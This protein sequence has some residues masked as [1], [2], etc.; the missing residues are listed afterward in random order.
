MR[1]CRERLANP[2]VESAFSEPILDERHLERLDHLLPLGV[3]R[4]EPAIALDSR[5]CYLISRPCHHGAFP[6]A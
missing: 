2:Q 5:G 6:S 4:A 3:R 1:P